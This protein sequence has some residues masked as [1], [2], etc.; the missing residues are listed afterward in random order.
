LYSLPETLP[1]DHKEAI[2]AINRKTKSHHGSTL[3]TLG[4]AAEHLAKSNSFLATCPDR[5]D[6]EAIHILMRV[7]REVFEEYA[8]ITR[9]RHPVTDWIM[10]QAVRVYG[11][12]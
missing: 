2:L 7:S 1:A 10:S 8:D 4:R 9:Q 3:R 6:R 12:A 11:A 5:G